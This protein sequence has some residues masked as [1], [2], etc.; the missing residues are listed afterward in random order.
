M[1][2]K[3]ET[4]VYE[5]LS[6]HRKNEVVYRGWYPTS[7]C[8]NCGGTTMM[9][10]LEGSGS[11]GGVKKHIDVTGYGYDRKTGQPVWIDT[12]GNRIRHDDSRVRYNLKTDQHGWKATGHK[13]R[14]YDRKGRRI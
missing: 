6:C 1:T 8:P 11:L 5:C 3:Q 13:T 9:E 12:K 4:V 7:V 14:N 10:G 2:D